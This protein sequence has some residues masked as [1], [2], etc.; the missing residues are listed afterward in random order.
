M[1][2]VERPPKLFELLPCPEKP[3]PWLFCLLC[4]FFACFSIFFPIK[5]EETD[6][7]FEET[8]HQ[9]EI[10]KVFEKRGNGSKI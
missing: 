6:L 1:N 2:L 5:F 8:D 10:I 4:L 3:S 9:I 7:N